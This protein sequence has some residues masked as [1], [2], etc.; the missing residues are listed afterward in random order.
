MIR[1]AGHRLTELPASS[2]PYRPHPTDTA[3]GAWLGVSQ[4][5]DSDQCLAVLAPHIYDYLVVDHYGLD[6]HW[7]SQMRQACKKLMMIDDIAD[8]RHDCDLLLDQNLFADASERYASKLRPQCR[9][10]LGPNYALLQPHYAEHRK[11]VIPRIGPVGSV[12][13]YFG[14]ADQTNLT[15]KAVKGLIP[16]AGVT[17]HIVISQNSRFYKDVA[18]DI[19]GQEHM[20]LHASLPSLAPLMAQCDLAV[21][22]GGATSWERCCLGLPSLIITLAD[23]Q[24]PLTK[25]LDRQGYV[26]WLGPQEQVT[27]AQIDTA[28]GQAMTGQDDSGWS[29]KCMRLVDGGGTDRVCRALTAL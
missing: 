24:I 17:S 5:V 21:G 23:N 11:T 9:S 28:L 26:R 20:R 29:D 1:A 15:G 18:Q 13:V 22:A 16:F 10:L 6:H 27:Q 12:L 3:H 14:N 4:A 19:Q 7:Q 25:E 8:R 2:A